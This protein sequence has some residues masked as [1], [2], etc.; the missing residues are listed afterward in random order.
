MK[1]RFP[2]EMTAIE[3]ILCDGFRKRRLTFE[4]HRPAFGRFQ[5]DFT[6]EA[7]KLFVCADGDYWHSIA[8][9]MVRDYA[10]NARAISDGWTIIRF[11]EAVIRAQPEACIQ[12]VAKFI[13]SHQ[14]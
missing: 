6:F 10:F 8:S 11:S 2:A 1:Q 5:P 3:R 4:M 12:A 9:A 13:R 14:P 7:V